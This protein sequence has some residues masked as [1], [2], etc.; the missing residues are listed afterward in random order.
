MFRGGYAHNIDDKGRVIVPL[1]FRSLLGEKFVVTKGLDRCLWV[2][3]DE[4][5]RKLDGHLNAQPM[6]DPNAVRLQRFFSGEAVDAVT[7]AQGRVA[8]PSNLREYAAIEKEV[9]IVGSGNRIEIW[10]KA[11]WDGMN[12]A[13]SDDLIRAAAQEIGLGGVG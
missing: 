1:K 12:S 13:L 7:D 6:L 11:G 5:F 9:M 8:L 2:F 3:S 10:N 4:E